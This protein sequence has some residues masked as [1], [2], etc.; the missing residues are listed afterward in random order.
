L[1]RKILR[2][3]FVSFCEKGAG[4]R[5]IVRPEQIGDSRRCRN[6]SRRF[7]NRTRIISHLLNKSERANPITRRNGLLILRAA[8]G[9]APLGGNGNICNLQ[10]KH[11]D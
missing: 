9:F 2:R 3:H 6:A 4:F 10:H 5:L 1:F 7:L 8:R 11:E